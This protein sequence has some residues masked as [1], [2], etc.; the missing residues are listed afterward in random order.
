[1]G[2]QERYRLIVYGWKNS[3]QDKSDLFKI[4]KATSKVRIM[5]LER[6]KH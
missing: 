1:M 2:Q 6:K 4:K 5:Y 3:K